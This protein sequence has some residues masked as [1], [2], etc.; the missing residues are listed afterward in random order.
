MCSAFN[1]ADSCVCGWGGEGHLGRSD[2]PRS[3]FYDLEK[4]FCVKTK[5]PYCEEYVFFVRHNGGSVWFDELG[6]PW[7]KHDCFYESPGAT[8]EEKTAIAGIDR[9]LASLSDPCFGV[10][11][12]IST[13]DS[14]HI[15]VYCCDNTLREMRVLVTFSVEAFLHEFVIFS[16]NEHKLI[17]PYLSLET[18]LGIEKEKV[19]R[20]V[21]PSQEDMN[22]LQ[23]AALAERWNCKFCLAQFTEYEGLSAHYRT[24][25]NTRVNA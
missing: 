8:R 25:R 21:E 12:D 10:V 17:R 1:H 5:C 9:W 4:E 11:T 20:V 24:H 7:P 15:T 2:G 16:S 18:V 3:I 13:D 14:K 19:L 23:T 6:K 22:E